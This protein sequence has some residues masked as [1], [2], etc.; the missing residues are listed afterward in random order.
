METRDQKRN[1]T[2]LLIYSIG[3]LTGMAIAAGLIWSDLEASLFDSGISPASLLQLNCPVAISTHE[4]GMIS[5]TIENPTEK[6]KS[7]FMRTHISEG[8]LSLMREIKGQVSVPPDDK[9]TISWEIFAED[10]VYDR[11]VMFRIY[12]N[13]SYPLPSQGNFCGV[14]VLD[15]PWLTG[16][17]FF[18]TLLVISL[19]AVIGGSILWRKA[20]P[21]MT[22]NTQSL[23]NAMNA[24]ALI[25]FGMIAISYYGLWVLG[26][27][28]F[29][30]SILLMGIILGRF[31]AMRR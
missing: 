16:T 1:I 31:F 28:F 20:N 26:I 8:Y 4:T 27:V 21:R 15:I 29:A 23:T 9:E 13:P 25:I 24:L 11:V 3:I 22:E 19:A 18:I 14:L 2:S 12:I 17:Q 6:E 30:I 10:A 7:F 5:A